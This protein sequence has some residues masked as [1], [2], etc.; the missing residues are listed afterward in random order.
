GA[1]IG[2][3]AVHAHRIGD[4]LDLAVTERLVSA[5]QLVF[6][7][8]VNAAGDV[9]LAG[10]G[11]AFK[12]RGNIDTVAIDVVGFDDDV[13]KMDASSILDP[14]M[15]RQRCVAA[16]QILLDDDAASDGLDGTVENR[17]KAV[18]RCFDEFSVV[19]DDAGLDELALDPLDAV[20]RSLFIDLHQAA[21]ARDIAC[22]DR[23]KATRGRLARGLAASSAR[24]DVANFR[25][26]SEWFP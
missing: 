18:A 26:G 9:D 5:N 19:F 8:F 12:P 7:L 6:Y 16:D 3:H 14:V 22:N 25:H 23:R 17:D 15:L 13:A 21:I 11:D 1:R 10:I 20:V 4:V 24:F 2:K